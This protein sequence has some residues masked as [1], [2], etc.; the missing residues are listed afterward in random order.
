MTTI[1]NPVTGAEAHPGIILP[2]GIILKRVD[3]GTSALFK[4]DDAISLDHSGH[5]TAVGEFDYAWP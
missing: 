4:V 5:Y 3:L 1:K 2:E